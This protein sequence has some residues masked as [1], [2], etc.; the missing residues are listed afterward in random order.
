[1]IGNYVPRKSRCTALRI[2]EIRINDH[3][4]VRL[5]SFPIE[6]NYRGA[7]YY[8]YMRFQCLTDREHSSPYIH[9]PSISE[10]ID[11]VYCDDDNKGFALYIFRIVQ[12]SGISCMDTITLYLRGKVKE[13]KYKERHEQINSRAVVC[14]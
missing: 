11:L 10:P 2:S 9:N 12:H 13:G 14:L 8:I 6:F 5:A 1:M 4:V 3:N 7:V